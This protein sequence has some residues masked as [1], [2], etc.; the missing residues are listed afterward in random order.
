MRAAKINKYPRCEGWCRLKK[1]Y[2]ILRLRPRAAA[3][4][5]AAAALLVCT[6]FCCQPLAREASVPA[7]GGTVYLT[8]DDGPSAVTA[9]ILEVLEE[10]QVPA[11]FFV[12]G[13]SAEEHPELL[14]Q[15]H[16]AGHRIGVHAYTHDYSLLYSS[17]A[18]FWDEAEACAEI[19]ES[20]TGE[21]PTLLRFP[22]GSGNTVCRVASG[23]GG[24]M[25]RLTQGCAGRGYV[26]HDWNVDPG[27]N[28]GYT[29]DAYTLAQRVV[30]GC[31]GKDSAVV[32][33]H[34]SAS[35]STGPEALRSIIPQLIEMGYSFSTLD[36]LEQ[37]PHQT[38][39]G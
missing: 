1:P 24:L 20:V 38:L 14:Q 2:L 15:I 11:T 36:R 39:A 25:Q 19:I 35:A 37:P 34:D 6:V 32:L 29:L 8:F 27:D 3:A 26:Y 10:Y 23:D 31:R 7:G 28:L 4:L 16:Q 22:G 18:A 13:K 12:I 21:T 30:E 9:E 5:F 33:M 17:E